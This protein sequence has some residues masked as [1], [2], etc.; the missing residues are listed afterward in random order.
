VLH[1]LKLFR[2]FSWMCLSIYKICGFGSLR[3]VLRNET[4]SLK[5]FVKPNNDACVIRLKGRTD[6]V[7]STGVKIVCNQSVR[8]VQVRTCVLSNRTGR[9]ERKAKWKHKRLPVGVNV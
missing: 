5:G 2:V 6:I 1:I 3:L 7:R 9:A 4:W 8:D